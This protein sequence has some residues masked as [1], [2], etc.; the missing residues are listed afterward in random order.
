MAYP[1]HHYRE[2]AKW[3]HHCLD[4][5]RRRGEAEQRRAA[6]GLDESPDSNVTEV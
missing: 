3:A 4:A 6:S 1:D 5:A 2:M